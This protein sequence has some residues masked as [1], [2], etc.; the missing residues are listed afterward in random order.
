MTVTRNRLVLIVSVF[1]LVLLA[2]HSA[3][4]AGAVYWDPATGGNGHVYEYV[5]KSM[6]FETARTTASAQNVSGATGHLAT[7]QNAAENA[8]LRQLAFPGSSKGNAWIGLSQPPGSPEPNG[9][10]QWVTRRTVGL[11]QLVGV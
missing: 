10:F 4:L 3:A 5:G 6:G 11:H 9:D 2:H 1:A 7:I 8:F